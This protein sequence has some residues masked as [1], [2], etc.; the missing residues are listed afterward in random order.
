MKWGWYLWGANLVQDGAS[1][2]QGGDAMEV[3]GVLVQHPMAHHSA[4]VEVGD[5]RWCIIQPR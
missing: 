3:H 5:V 1:F 2:G 4:K